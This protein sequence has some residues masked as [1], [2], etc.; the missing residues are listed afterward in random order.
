MA[1]SPTPSHVSEVCLSGEE[2]QPDVLVSSSQQPPQTLDGRAV[3]E[4]GETDIPHGYTD[5]IDTFVARI[6]VGSPDYCRAALL[7]MYSLG[8][9]DGVI[10][11]IRATRGK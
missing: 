2:S 10:D 5:L 7:A 3:P 11:A 9:T 6:R 8:R 1:A 4:A